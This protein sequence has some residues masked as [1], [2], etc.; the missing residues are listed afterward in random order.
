MMSERGLG[1][2]QKCGRLVP[3]YNHNQIFR[4]YISDQLWLSLP[5]FYSQLLSNWR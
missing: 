1:L 5:L 3:S 2:L 4:S